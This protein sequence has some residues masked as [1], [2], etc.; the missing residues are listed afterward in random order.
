MERSETL[1]EDSRHY[2][3][4]DGNSAMR[5]EIPLPHEESDSTLV[6]VLEK[7]DINYGVQPDS[8]IVSKALNLFGDTL[9][10]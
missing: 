5:D 10:T 9:N 2:M 3:N 8:Y 4:S 7:V 6:D 1:L